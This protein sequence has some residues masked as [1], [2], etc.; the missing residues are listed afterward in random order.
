M[1]AYIFV[2]VL[3]ARA[4]KIPGILFTLVQKI[5]NRPDMAILLVISKRAFR[6]N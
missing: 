4:S 3:N 2:C 6:G 1:Y 5:S